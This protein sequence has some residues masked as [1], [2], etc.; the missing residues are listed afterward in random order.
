MTE[1]HPTCMSPLSHSSAKLGR[2][3]CFSV[4]EKALSS[5]AVALISSGIEGPELGAVAYK[6]APKAR[7]LVQKSLMLILG[8]VMDTCPWTL[9]LLPSLRG[10]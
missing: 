9:S 8:G 10:W 5:P 1:V 7:S 6:T 3:V 2:I 4:G